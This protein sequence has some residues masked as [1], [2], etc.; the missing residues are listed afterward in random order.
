MLETCM[1]GLQESSSLSKVTRTH[2]Q[3][4]EIQWERH[5]N[6]YLIHPDQ[7]A[8]IRAYA[9]MF[10]DRDRYGHGNPPEY[11]VTTIQLDNDFFDLHYAKEREVLSRFKLRVRTYGDPGSAPVFMEIKRKYRQTIVK[12]RVFIPFD[13][14][15]EDLVFNPRLTLDFSSAKEEEAFL[16]F[17]RLCREIGARPKTIIRYVRE[18][19]LSR[20]DR[21]ARVTFDRKLEYQPTTSWTD[22]GRS[23]RWIPMDTPVAQGQGFPYSAVV[24]ELKCLSDAPV[25]MQGLIETFDLVRTGNC[26]YSTALWQE[27]P[28]TGE[29][30]VTLAP[31]GQAFL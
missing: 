22:W 25:W 28:F 21:Y 29:P 20:C 7:V 12:S 10:C 16:E 6:K 11:T 3:G 18:C 17:V 19:Y 8:P 14:W 15:S 23:G 24:L 30:L 13:A 1:Q 9:R 5:E 26:K 4:F 27:A 2:P 31:A